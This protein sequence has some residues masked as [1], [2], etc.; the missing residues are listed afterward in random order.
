MTDS[1]GYTDNI[2]LLIWKYA[3]QG[4]FNKPVLGS[5]LYSATY[6]SQLYVR[7]VTHNSFVDILVGQG[8]IGVIFWIGIFAK[9]IMV[10]KG[11][12]MFVL[13]IIFVFMFP[14]FF[15]NG[16][17]TLSFWLPMILIKQISDC[18]KKHDFFELF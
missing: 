5:G 4:F 10:K 8:I 3:M 15:L 7:W 9:F 11:N 14:Y 1:S 18:C 2:R 6:Y 13:N 17:E 16:Y 12:G